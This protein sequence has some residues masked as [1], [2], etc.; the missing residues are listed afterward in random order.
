MPYDPLFFRL[1]AKDV[2][3][4]VVNREDGVELV[5]AVAYEHNA[6][7][8]DDTR[9]KPDSDDGNRDGY[10]HGPYDNAHDHHHTPDEGGGEEDV[11]VAVVVAMAAALVARKPCRHKP[12]YRPAYMQIFYSYV[13]L[14][15][16]NCS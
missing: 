3:E 9:E 6:P 16:S 12:A 1:S 11:S 2:A 4:A 5:D 7:G 13:Q 14:K 10:G 15:D 8:D